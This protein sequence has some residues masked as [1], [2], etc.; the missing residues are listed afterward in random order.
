MEAAVIHST[1]T[2]FTH[3]GTGTVRMCFPLPTTV[4]R[5]SPSVPHESG[6]P[7]FR[8]QPV[9]RLADRTRQVVPESP[10]HAC[11]GVRLTIVCQARSWMDRQSTNCRSAYPNVLLRSH[12]GFPR[13]VPGSE[14]QYQ[15]LRR[16]TRL[17]A[18]K[19]TLM[20]EGARSSVR[21]KT[22]SEERQFG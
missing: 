14:G 18:A 15:R 6:N 5:R 16:P 2:P 9:R 12:D 21:E 7:P 20:V 19:R 10:D 11:H 1:T 17:T 13:P 4:S 22:G 8:V 3:P